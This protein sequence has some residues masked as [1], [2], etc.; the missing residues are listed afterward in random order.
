MVLCIGILMLLFVGCQQETSEMEKMKKEYPGSFSF[1]IQN[2]FHIERIDAPVYLDIET[3]AHKCQ[4]FDSEA[5]IVYCNE[6]EVASQAN[7]FNNDGRN[8]QIVFV[9]DFKPREEKRVTIQFS[10]DRRIKKEYPKRT[11]AEVSHKIGG[12]FID[13]KYEGGKF[14]N[15]QFVRVPPEHID[16]DTYFR[17]EGPGWESDKVGYRFYLDWRNAIDIFGK[18]V[19]DMVLQDVGLDGFDSYHEMAD[20]GMDILKVG[21]SM[22]IGSIGM[23]H[24]EKVYMVSETDSIWCRIVANGPVHSQIETRYFGWKVD[25]EKY[26]LT[27]SLSITAGCRLT[28]HTVEITGN[29][30]NV[31]TGLAKHPKGKLIHSQSSRNTGWNY[32]SVFG[33]QSLTDDLLVT[34]VVYRDEDFLDFVEDELSYI[35]LLNPRSGSLTYFFL[36]AWEQEPGGI[37]TRD[38]FR[39]YINEMMMK[40]N[41][42]IQ[43]S[44]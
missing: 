26:D 41:N 34:A 23:W 10:P 27:S 40:L 1:S 24:D 30:E 36:A 20:W 29:P 19:S 5:F 44:F 6:K 21:E 25:A 13:K 12:S 35:I 28:K 15:V 16:H 3:I 8:D 31:C 9:T 4:D 37:Q 11:Q 22:G 38:E 42:P 17:Y 43:V 33:Q 18:K 7:D 14:K 2:T 32:M 39:R